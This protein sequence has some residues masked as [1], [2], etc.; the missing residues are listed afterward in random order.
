MNCFLDILSFDVFMY[1]VYFF[2]TQRENVTTTI[3]TLTAFSILSKIINKVIKY[4][5]KLLKIR[6]ILSQHTS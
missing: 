3:S 4:G 1:D 6:T 5:K 2:L